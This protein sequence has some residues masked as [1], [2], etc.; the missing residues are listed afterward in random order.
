MKS[1]KLIVTSL[2]LLI[3]ANLM[4]QQG[5]IDNWRPYGQEG[6]N[7]FEA[8]KEPDATFDGLKVRIGGAFTQ[9][10]Q[11]LDHSNN[12]EYDTIT[13]RGKP[14][15]GN[16]LYAI[17]PG[18]NLAT[19]NL[20]IDAQLADGIRVAI[21]NYMSARHHEEFW[22]KGGYIQID[23]LPMFNSPDWFSKYMR[24]KIGHFQVNYGDQ[25]FRR[26]DN[27]NTM[28]NPFVGNY[29]MDAFATEIGGEAY[30]FLPSGFMGMVGMTSGLI[31]GNVQNVTGEDPRDPSIYAKLAYDKQISDDFRFRL[32]GSVY[33][34]SGVG[35]NTLYAGDR[36]GS[37]FYYAMEPAYY[38]PRGATAYIPADATGLFTSGRMSPGFSSEVTSFVINPFIKFKGLEV[39]GTYEQSKGMAYTDPK[40]EGA[41]KPEARTVNQFAVEGVYRFLANEQVFVGARYQQVS[42][43]LNANIRE[44]NAP[45]ELSVNRLEVS[46]GWFPIKN[47]LLKAAY[48]DQKYQDYPSS[49]ILSEGEFHGFMVEAALAF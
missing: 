47:L 41:E 46:A 6:I 23:K 36:A 27:G 5:K 18:F 9:Q 31:G 2:A 15:N 16:E 34:N 4:A 25:Q 30:L 12:A 11:A 24:V 1:A 21:E 33:M 17:A 43:E 40:A 7:I 20:F 8:P 44:N 48:V 38:L 35:R 42:G 19:A 39:F 32:S 45:K 28:Y 22:V 29:I 10:Y 3:A 49:S 26:S 13:Y 14:A 37:R